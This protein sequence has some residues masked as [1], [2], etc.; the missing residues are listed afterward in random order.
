MAVVRMTETLAVEWAR[1]GI[2]VNAICPGGIAT[3]IF[4][5]QMALKPGGNTDY[6]AA[7]KPFLEKMQPIP[8][9]GD[10]FRG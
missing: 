3:P 5:G 7:M 6:A 10:P 1:N 8:R 2:N 4:A 9:A